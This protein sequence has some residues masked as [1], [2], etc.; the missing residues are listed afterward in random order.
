[1][2]EIFSLLETLI[3]FGAAI[4]IL[5][6]IHELGHFWVARA[7]GV[8]V[9]KFSVGFGP[10]LLSRKDRHGTVFA[11]S[12][13]PLGGYVKML[14]E[15]EGSVR[16]D[17]RHLSFN[18]QPPWQR[19][20]IALAGP[21]AN[22]LLAVIVFAAVAI[23]GSY[24]LVP[25]VDRV[26]AGSLAELAGVQPFDQIVAIDGSQVSSA[27]DLQMQL[28]GRVG[29]EAPITLTLE[30]RKSAQAS[31]ISAGSEARGHSQCKA[32]TELTRECSVALNG[33]LKDAAEPDVLKE[34]GLSLRLPKATLVVDAVSQE[35]AAARA[36]LNPGDRLVGIDDQ[37]A[38]TWEGFTQLVRNKPNTQVT[39]Q[40]ERAGV[41]YTK[42]VE[43]GSRTDAN[44]EVTG[45]LGVS[46]VIEQ[47]PPE[48]LIRQ[49][50][51]LAGSL[52]AGFDETLNTA[53]FVILSMKKLLFGEISVKN[54]SGPIGIAKVA[55]DSGK[56]GY[57]AFLNFLG[58]LSVYLCVLNLLP[59]PVLDG[60][61][62]L[63][64]LV[65]WI[66]GSPVSDTVQLAFQQVGLLMLFGLMV[67]ALY[68]D[69]L[70]IL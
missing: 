10:E 28:L 53:S 64:G 43:L 40:F 31:Q 36:G 7:C 63:Y 68:Y 2:S 6:S 39:L 52:P 50:S 33:W 59:I 45:L 15:R 47:L 16:E 17:Q 18:A 70:R 35:S 5:V 22:F 57:I 1:M 69:V 46:P 27:R 24:R 51:T 12:A 54:L 29:E 62:V 37:S 25:V 49:Q 8:K 20:L 41:A 38:K 60:G 14:D 58:M 61:H 67:L 4:L 23:Y 44:G 48:Y 55:G 11:L 65:E 32:L 56:A 19:I 42:S 34:F 21:F 9:L 30:S 66:K 26:E 3:W 13:I